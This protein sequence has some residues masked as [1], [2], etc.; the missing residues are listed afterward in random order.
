MGNRFR[1]DCRVDGTKACSC[2]FEALLECLFSEEDF[3]LGGVDEVESG[4]EGFVGF[5]RED[6]SG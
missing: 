6:V 4:F 5:G 1:V 3:G 2:G